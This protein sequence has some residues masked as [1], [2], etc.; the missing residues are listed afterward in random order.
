M[1]TQPVCLRDTVYNYVYCLITFHLQNKLEQ[2]EINF[3]A[4]SY[5]V[6]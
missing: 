1:I 3:G 5:C 4:D 6:G 2:A